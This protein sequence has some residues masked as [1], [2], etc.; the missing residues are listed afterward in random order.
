MVKTSLI[1][2]KSAIIVY[3]QKKIRIRPS[4]DTLT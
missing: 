2:V 3:L 4:Q 1:G